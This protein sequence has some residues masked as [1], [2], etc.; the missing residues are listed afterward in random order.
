MYFA[1]G[2]A[3]ALSMA[4][5]AYTQAGYIYSQ[6]IT[7]NS[8]FTLTAQQ[9]EKSNLTAVEA[10]NFEIAL[11]FERTNYAG[12]SVHSDPFYTVPSTFDPLRPPPP[13]TVLKVEQHTNTALYTIPPSLSMSRFLYTSETLNG[14]SIPASAYVL[15]PYTP[16]TFSGLSCKGKGSAFPV[17]GLAHG[18]SGTELIRGRKDDFANG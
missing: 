3:V 5:T 11:S 8:T 13:G 6:N 14:T 16:R 18:T 7:F 4:R 1:I 2:L 10:H 12:G 15:W 9:I 17:V